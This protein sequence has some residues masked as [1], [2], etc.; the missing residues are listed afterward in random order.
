VLC[1]FGVFARKSL[2]FEFFVFS[3]PAAALALLDSGAAPNLTDKMGNLPL[4]FACLGKGFARVDVLDQRPS[5]AG[6]DGNT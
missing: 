4:H 6:L 2:T 3:Q 5:S 1:C